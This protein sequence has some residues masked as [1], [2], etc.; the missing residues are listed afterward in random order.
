MIVNLGVS[1]FYHF[2]ISP[3]LF[4]GLATFTFTYFVQ[5]SREEQCR[6]PPAVGAEQPTSRHRQ[7]LLLLRYSLLFIRNPDKSLRLPSKRHSTS[8]APR[9]ATTPCLDLSHQLQ[10]QQDMNRT[11]GT[12]MPPAVAPPRCTDGWA[13][14]CLSH[15]TLRPRK[16]PTP[17]AG[18][19][20]PSNIQPPTSCFPRRRFCPRIRTLLVP[21]S[22]R[23]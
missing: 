14:S 13:T 15:T 17:S 22:D 20:I 18:W 7:S 10:Q 4:C 8:P 9:G 5:V 2:A 16:K 11:T 1:H 21:P 12:R 6:P 3:L 19:N 23:Y